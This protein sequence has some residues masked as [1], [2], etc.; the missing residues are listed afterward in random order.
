MNEKENSGPSRPEFFIQLCGAGGRQCRRNFLIN[1]FERL[2]F[3][4][5]IMPF[6]WSVT[7]MRF[8]SGMSG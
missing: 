8:T 7:G 2:G 5:Q 6:S 4:T 3:H 1:V